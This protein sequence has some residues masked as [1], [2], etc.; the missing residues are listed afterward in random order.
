M[1]TAAELFDTL[2]VE[3][4][5]FTFLG[6]IGAIGSSI[7]LYF[8]SVKQCQRETAVEV[9]K[10]SKRSFRQSQAILTIASA[11]DN[12]IIRNHDEPSTLRTDVNTELRDENNNL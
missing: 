5:V 11:I 3:F 6:I 4:A 8:R 12:S 9:D 1:A 10:L 2:F 7:L